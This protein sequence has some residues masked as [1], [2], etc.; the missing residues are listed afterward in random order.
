ICQNKAISFI[1]SNLKANRNNR[2]LI[3]EFIKERQIENC[4]ELFEIQ[5][6]TDLNKDNI[7]ELILR[8]KNSP[9]GMLYC[10]ATGNC[11]TWI[12][13]KSGNKYQIIFDAGSIEK[14]EIKNQI[15]RS[16]RNLLIRGHLG[17]MNHYLG[18]A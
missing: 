8:A 6:E 16:Y 13:S 17:A 10:G 12:L 4:N 2:K 15:T 18:T 9:K 1:L 5:P 3:T 11:S 14:L 7:K